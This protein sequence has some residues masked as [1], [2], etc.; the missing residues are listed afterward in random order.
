MVILDEAWALLDKPFCAEFIEKAYRQ[1]RKFGA[2]IGII[3]QGF[4]DVDK[5]QGGKGRALLEN[6]NWIFALKQNQSALKQAVDKNIIDI[7]E[8]Q[9][10][11]VRSIQK[12]NDYSEFLV[13]NV[14]TN[15]DALCRFVTDKFTYAM[16]SSTAEQRAQIEKD[17]SRGM[18][19]VDAVDK[20]AKSLDER[21][22][23]K[24]D[25]AADKEKDN[26]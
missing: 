20:L 4:G 2:S 8:R 14:A 9:Q 7:D 1:F 10:Q 15:A 11:M 26:D 19:R 12:N 18:S 6:C 5:A 17:V 25:E 3:T 16:Y 24:G 21:A 23:F 22:M 13:I